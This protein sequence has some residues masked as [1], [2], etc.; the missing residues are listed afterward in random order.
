MFLGEYSYLLLWRINNQESQLLRY[1]WLN[2]VDKFFEMDGEI[3]KFIVGRLNYVE[4]LRFYYKC[5]ELFLWSC[6]QR[7]YMC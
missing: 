4:D 3:Y 6:K 2:F 1:K 7:I 5:S